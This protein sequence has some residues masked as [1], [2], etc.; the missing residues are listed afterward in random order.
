[1]ASGSREQP[2]GEGGVRPAVE[3]AC[4]PCD[5]L[6][7]MKVRDLM[8]EHVVTVRPHDQVGHARHLLDYYRVSAL[9]VL[10]AEGHPAGIITTTD[11]AGDVSDEAL[12]NQVMAG[13]VYTVPHMAGAHVAARMMRKHH[14][15]HLVV[16]QAREI[17]GVI[18]SFDL[19]RLT[20]E[21]RFVV[22]PPEEDEE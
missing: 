16:T 10:D 21:R 1:V 15:H 13:R 20:E 4:V 8:S 17:V 7:R 22:A 2:T 11:L 6:E 3:P 18:S 9:P 19:L 5:R 14:V 12:V